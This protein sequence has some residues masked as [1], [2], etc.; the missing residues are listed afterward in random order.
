MNRSFFP[1]LSKTSSQVGM[2]TSCC[3][4]PV[5]KSEE[6]KSHSLA[7]LLASVSFEFGFELIG[8]QIAHDARREY[9]GDDNDGRSNQRPPIG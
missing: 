7:V 4:R 2:K 1:I 6:E 9:A 8:F 5:P 3:L